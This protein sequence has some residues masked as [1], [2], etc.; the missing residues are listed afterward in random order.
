MPLALVTGAPGWLGT[1]LVE[2]LI[3]GLPDVPRLRAPTA[4]LEVRCL[5]RPGQPAEELA[6]LG[7]RVVTVAGDLCDPGSLAR[8]VEPARGATLFHVAGV[9]HPTRGTRELLQVNAEGTR[10]LLQAAAR[11]GVRRFVHVS[12]NSPIGVNASPAESFDESAPYAPYLTYGLSK[13]LAEDHVNAAGRRGDLETVIVR[14]PWFYGPRQPPRQSLFFS[15]I[16]RGEVPIV[17]GGENRRSMAYVGNICHGLLLAA[18]TPEAASETFWIA[19]AEPYTMNE[20][21]DTIE[22]V[23]ERDF[24]LA[25]AHRRVRLP[26][27]ASEL[28]WLGDRALQSVGLYHQK[29]HVL[30]EMNKTIACRIDKARRVLGYEPAIALEEGM[31]RS[32]RWCLDHGGVV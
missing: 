7:P 15:M 3:H 29:L 28:A 25:C 18:Q 20:I 10:E 27:L 14:P 6:A 11:A 32:L 24:G 1:S 31:R 21:V 17:G 5:V 26:G 30:S 12:S 22:R 16:R 4:D 2:A 8:F 9:V 23:L 19:D 13:K